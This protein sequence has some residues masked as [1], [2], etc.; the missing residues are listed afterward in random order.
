[1]T[2]LEQIAGGRLVPIMT[3]DDAADAG[4]TGRRA[5]GRWG[6]GRRR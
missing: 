6:C 4:P 1:M 3:V 2:V 5:A